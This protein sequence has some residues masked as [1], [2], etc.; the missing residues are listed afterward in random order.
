MRSFYTRTNGQRVRNGSPITRIIICWIHFR[1][2]FSYLHTHETND[3]SEIDPSHILS[4]I[5][6]NW[7]VGACGF[8]ADRRSTEFCLKRFLVDGSNIWKQRNSVCWNPSN[9][10][11]ILIAQFSDGI[12]IFAMYVVLR[13][14]TVYSSNGSIEK[15]TVN[16][17]I[18]Q[19]YNIHTILLCPWK[20]TSPF[21][22]W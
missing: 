10:K 15:R 21:G 9:M 22:I 18:V 3:Q 1:A 11:M 14:K 19:W 8:L 7:L 17:N 2:C 12:T 13:T 20:L 16:F 6:D 5:W 4:I